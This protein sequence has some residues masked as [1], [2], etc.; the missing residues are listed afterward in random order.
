[1]PL[2]T[3]QGNGSDIIECNR[4]EWKGSRNISDDVYSNRLTRNQMVGGNGLVTNR[5]LRAVTRLTAFLD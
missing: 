4:E 3:P 2:T 5:T 1:M